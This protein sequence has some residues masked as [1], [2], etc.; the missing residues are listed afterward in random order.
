MPFL[1]INSL[2]VYIE[3]LF[4]LLDRFTISVEFTGAVRAAGGPK[5]TDTQFYLRNNFGN[6]ASILT[7][8]SLLQAEFMA[9]KRDSSSTH[10][11]FI[12]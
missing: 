1:Q 11:T 6:S 8:L 10:H 5:K 2:Q 9:R 4:A 3:F 7:I 12:V